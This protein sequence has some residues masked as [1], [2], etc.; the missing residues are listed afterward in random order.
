MINR[1]ALLI[2]VLTLSGCS[3]LYPY[4]PISP[5]VKLGPSNVSDIEIMPTPSAGSGG[6]VAPNSGGTYRG[7]WNAAGSG[8]YTG[9]WSYTGTNIQTSPLLPLNKPGTLSC[10]DTR[11]KKHG[12]VP[13][14]RECEVKKAID[15]AN[16][17][18][19][20]YLKAQG[21]HADMP[22]LGG[23]MLVPAAAAASAL[24]I[25]GMGATAI[26]G[27]GAGAAAIYG[28]GSYLHTPDRE[29]VYN[30]G[31]LGIQCMLENMEPYTRIDS[32]DLLVL[33]H[34]IDSGTVLTGDDYVD[35]S[36]LDLTNAKTW[37]DIQINKVEAL[38][39]QNNCQ[40]LPNVMKTAS[41]L[42]K[43]AKAADKAADKAVQVGNDFAQ[44][45]LAAPITIV[46]TTNHI[47]AAL[48][49]AL[50]KTEP[51]LS[52]LAGNIKGI[53]PDKEQAVAGLSAAQNSAADAQTQLANATS[54]GAGAKPKV[55]AP[56]GKPSPHLETL[57]EKVENFGLA[58]PSAQATPST[59][60][61]IEATPELTPPGFSPEET[62]QLRKLER[63]IYVVNELTS[64]V[65][66]IVGSYT[67]KVDNS[68]CP[69]LA[70]KAGTV[71]AMKLNPSGDVVVS[72]GSNTKITI[73]G[74]TDPY[75]RPLFPQS[76]CSAVTATLKSA[77]IDVA[78]TGD[79]I[80]GFYPFFAGDGAT[81]R[82]FNVM[83]TPKAP[84]DNTD[85]VRKC[86]PGKAGHPETADPGY[87]PP[88]S[89]E[90]GQTKYSCP[91]ALVLMAQPTAAPTPDPA[92]AAAKK[93]EAA[94][95][96]AAAAA[97]LA[98]AAAAGAAA[99]APAAA[100]SP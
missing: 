1:S 13:P 21:Q 90:L 100:P 95:K 46:N 59:P 89:D 26:T 6:S 30:T 55:A 16:R 86:K 97:K 17:A 70:K 50:I 67:G 47:N 20:E 77:E 7:S 48:N 92:V 10:G 56:A 3:S 87:V 69:I 85:E 43:A 88:E 82:I 29:T 9:Q 5:T 11:P 51:N 37:L 2:V 44:T 94:R 83:V 65:L 93:A 23:L 12:N 39:L 18:N 35:E 36:T 33:T 78:A 25:E 15:Y 80:P 8:T 40:R 61:P 96:K 14:T 75:T 98:G 4:Y 53:I 41:L 79:T 99:K 74:A 31:A 49:G 42:L 28:L 72:Q 38:G 62:A 32:D 73:S 19:K 68:K 91:P 66:R 22:G 34:T 60:T 76:V 71:T 84:K 24:A 54:S 27:L 64:R 45:A 58:Q 52:A 81:G 63:S 57:K